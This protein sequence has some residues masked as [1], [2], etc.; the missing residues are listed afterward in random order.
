MSVKEIRVHR[1]MGCSLNDYMQVKTD[2]LLEDI[3]SKEIEP[4]PEE[5]AEWLGRLRL[6]YGVPFEYLVPEERMLPKES[7][8]FFFLDRNWIDRLV[9]G[10]LTIGKLGTRDYMH[11]EHRIDS[12]HNSLSLAEVNMRKA[13]RGEELDPSLDVAVGGTVTGVFIRS[14]LVADYPGVEVRGYDKPSINS[15]KKKLQLLR[16][17]RLAPD[18]LCCL[19]HGVPK[20]MEMEEPREGIQF[21]VEEK[22][23]YRPRADTGKYES[24]EVVYK[25]VPMRSVAQVGEPRVIDIKQFASDI[26]A[27]DDSS[28]V[29]I[30]LLQ[31]PYLQQFDKGGECAGDGSGSDAGSFVNAVDFGLFQSFKSP[32]GVNQETLQSLQHSFEVVLGDPVDLM[33]NFT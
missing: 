5:L 6:L 26:G 33:S 30:Q 3:S 11:H 24:D 20:S 2:N 8:R 28:K 29:A 19:F 17:D 16:M 1:T 31:F 27:D 12:I 21:G 25:D 9:D 18:I 4:L 14:S 10:A 22:N 23:Q 13:L 7:I 15:L 32:R